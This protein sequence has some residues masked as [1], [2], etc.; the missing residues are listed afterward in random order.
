MGREAWV[1]MKGYIHP[2]YGTREPFR[3]KSDLRTPPV[4]CLLCKNEPEN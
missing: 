3:Q 2:A 1:Y 4:V